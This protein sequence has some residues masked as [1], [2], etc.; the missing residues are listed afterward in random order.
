MGITHRGS[1]CLFSFG[2]TF[3]LNFNLTFTFKR[4]P[5]SGILR[6]LGWLF[7]VNGQAAGD[8]VAAGLEPRAIALVEHKRNQLGLGRARAVRAPDVAHF[9]RVTLGLMFGTPGD[10]LTMELRRLPCVSRA[11]PETAAIRAT[12]TE[13]QVT[14]GVVAVAGGVVA[15][16]GGAVTLWGVGCGGET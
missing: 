3:N 4:E 15:V 16:H 14:V 11:L 1:E 8:A 10:V 12:P 9:M 7:F 5:L 2:G 6:C 13:L